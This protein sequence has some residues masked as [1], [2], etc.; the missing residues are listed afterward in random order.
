MGTAQREGKDLQ[1]FPEEIGGGHF[2]SLNGSLAVETFTRIALLGSGQPFIH[3]PRGGGMTY[4]ITEFRR[5]NCDSVTQSFPGR[6]PPV[7]LLR[8]I[9]FT[10][11]G[12]CREGAAC[13]WVSEFSTGGETGKSTWLPYL[14]LHSPARPPLLLSF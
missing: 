10:E 2:L 12:L 4:L 9:N 1:G 3:L 11:A 13:S 5:G 7:L 8:A 6:D 14:K